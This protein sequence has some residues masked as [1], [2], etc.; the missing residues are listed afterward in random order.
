MSWWPFGQSKSQN[1][2]PANEIDARVPPPPSGG[3]LAPPP[4]L[5]PS[6]KNSGSSFQASSGNGPTFT[7]FTPPPAAPG[8]LLGESSPSAPVTPPKGVKLPTFGFAKRKPAEEEGED[9]YATENLGKYTSQVNE[10]DGLRDHE[11]ASSSSRSGS[12]NFSNFFNFSN[13]RARHCFESVKTGGL[14]GASV[15][16]IFGGL[17][18]VYASI[19]NRNILILP[20]ST[21]GGA[22][23]FGFF[24]GCGMIVRC[25]GDAENRAPR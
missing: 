15:G 10:S 11:I 9:R 19:V 6:L 2:E 23:S 21:L 8:G 13:P 14:M 7:G 3:F 22:M 20:I 4:E 16:G 18:G 12:T 25:E 1:S 24:L 5:P 17:M